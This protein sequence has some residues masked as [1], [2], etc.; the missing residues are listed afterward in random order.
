MTANRNPGLD[1]VGVGAGLD[2]IFGEDDD[3]ECWHELHDDD[4]LG[5]RNPVF[6]YRS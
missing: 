5:L 4:G 6:R 1:G 3:G 2:D